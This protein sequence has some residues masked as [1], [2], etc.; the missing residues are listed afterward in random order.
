MIKINQS[1]IANNKSIIKINQSII[2]N[3]ESMINNQSINQS[4]ITINQ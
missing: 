4:L 3:N 1:N 2:E